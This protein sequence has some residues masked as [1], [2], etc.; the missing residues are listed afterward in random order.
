MPAGFRVLNLLHAVMAGVNAVF[1]FCELMGF[2]TLS[3]FKVIVSA[4]LF[5]PIVEE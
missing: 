5:V 4:G 2:N 1:T 3:Y